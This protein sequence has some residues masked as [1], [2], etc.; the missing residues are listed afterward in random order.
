MDMLKLAFRTL[1]TFVFFDYIKKADNI[2]L[3]IDKSL[4]EEGEVL[5]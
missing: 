4:K 2:I 5:I 1:L 3:A